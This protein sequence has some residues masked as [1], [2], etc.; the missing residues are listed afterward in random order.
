LPESAADD[1]VG[2]AAASRARRRTVRERSDALIVACTKPLVVTIS[3][4]RLR[5]VGRKV[6][7]PR[8]MRSHRRGTEASF[9]LIY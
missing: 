5:R 9:V 8:A 3:D 1:G 4:A 7:P 6:H 2:E